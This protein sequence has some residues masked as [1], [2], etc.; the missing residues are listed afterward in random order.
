L[1]KQ[2]I[3]AGR[4]RVGVLGLLS[5]SRELGYDIKAAGIRVNFSHNS[6]EFVWNGLQLNTFEAIFCD[7]LRELCANFL[8][9]LCCW[10]IAI[11]FQFFRCTVSGPLPFCHFCHLLTYFPF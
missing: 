4:K 9:W 1:K 10:R 6:P 11:Y 3:R 2:L 7:A 8:L 5:S